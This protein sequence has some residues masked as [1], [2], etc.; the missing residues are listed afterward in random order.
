MTGILTAT[1]HLHFCFGLRIGTIYIDRTGWYDM[2]L[3][4]LLQLHI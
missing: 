3:F 1:K 4:L 2:K